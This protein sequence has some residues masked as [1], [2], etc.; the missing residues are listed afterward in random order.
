MA[1]GPFPGAVETRAGAIPSKCYSFI[2]EPT[3]A[4][5]TQTQTDLWIPQEESRLST[6]EEEDSKSNEGVGRE[7][8]PTEE[9]QIRSVKEAPAPTKANKIK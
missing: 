3:E 9:A 8:P 2:Y 4:H 5:E 6:E 1:L 7:Y